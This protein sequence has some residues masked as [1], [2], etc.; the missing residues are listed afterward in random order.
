[1]SMINEYIEYQQK[2]EKLYGDNTI[3]LYQNGSFFEIFGIDNDIEKIGCPKEISETLNIILTRKN[4]IIKENTRKNPL[5]CGFQKDSIDKYLQILLNKNYTVVLVEQVTNPPNPKREVT[6]IFSPGTYMEESL[7]QIDSNFLVTIFIENLKDDKLAIGLSSVELTTGKCVVYETYSTN[8]DLTKP[9]DETF[10]F[11]QS[12]NPREVIIYNSSKKDQNYF[13]DFF[14][15]YH[16]PLQYRDLEN[17]EKDIKLVSKITYQEKFLEK[18]YKNNTIL[19]PIEYIDLEKNHFATKAFIGCLQFAFE[20]N[21]TIINNIE[22]PK[23]WKESEQLVLDY[24]AISQLNIIEN[25]EFKTLNKKTRYRSLF[26]VIKNTSTALGHRLLKQKLLEPIYDSEKLQLSYNQIDSMINKSEIYDKQG[27][28]NGIIFYETFLKQIIDLERLHRKIHLQRIQPYEFSILINSYNVVTQLLD[29][30]KSQKD[31]L[32]ILPSE[33]DCKKFEKYLKKINSYFNLE[34]LDGT[35]LTVPITNNIF[36]PGVFKEID[37]LS[38]KITETLDSFQKLQDKFSTVLNIKDSI[39]LVKNAKEGYYLTTTAKRFETLKKKL[40]KSTY[41]NLIVKTH[42]KFRTKQMDRSCDKLDELMSQF[43]SETKIC[44]TKILTEFSD[45]YSDIFIT[46]SNFI[47]TLDLIKSN[48]KTAMQNG[49]CKPKILK[50]SGNGS[51]LKAKVLRHP[52]GEK[53]ISLEE[54]V[55]NDVL[56]DNSDAGLLIY[57]INSSGKSNLMKA[58]GCNLIMAQAGMYVACKS[59]K[60]IPFERIMTRIRGEDNIFKGQSSF[61]V[62]MA[63]LRSILKR[64]NSKTLVLGDEICHG[65]EQISAQAI[66]AESIINLS[67]KDVKFI[68]ATH[69]H[70]LSDMKIIRDLENVKHSHFQVTYDNKEKKIIYNR[71]LAPGNGSSIYGIEVAEAMG[72]D[73]DFIKRAKEIRRSIID[74]SNNSSEVSKVLSDKCSRYNSDYFLEALCEFCNEVKATDVHHIKFQSTSDKNN[75]IDKR[76]HKNRKHNL[77]S[78]CKICHQ[79]IHTEPP[80]FKING[81]KMTSKGYE[82]IKEVN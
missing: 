20:H 59:F 46:I 23:I 75:L 37:E 65:T 49:Y 79:N 36:K 66:V 17:S 40:K 7:V 35:N 52:L 14:E 22:K 67:S 56:L 63:E 6:K 29:N 62:E 33:T 68:F 72:L 9:L 2:Y 24:N 32:K 19:S 48:A 39:K 77:V 76:F 30:E 3:V 44:F 5:M 13:I 73:L 61:A 38:E 8:D 70:S 64:A 45:E 80:I 10:R 42:N 34:E 4:K 25:F 1:M 74:S 60:F 55:P 50:D 53:L 58:V 71:T 81:Y 57:G 15:L 28:N 18:I 82:L 31:L 21:E 16:V 54:Y 12:Y 47:A 11:L 43:N 69:L 27:S 51:K 41:D 26:S 78:L